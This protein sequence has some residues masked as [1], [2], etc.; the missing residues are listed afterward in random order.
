VI[1]HPDSVE[2]KGTTI[3]LPE[4]K[5]GNAANLAK[6]LN[7]NTTVPS[8]QSVL[9]SLFVLNYNDTFKA[10]K[11]AIPA[12]NSL[13]A[14]A[15]QNTMFTFAQSISSHLSERR[16]FQLLRGKGYSLGAKKESFD[17]NEAIAC[18][19]LVKQ[20]PPKQSPA[21]KGS[22]LLFAKEKSRFDVWVDGFTEFSHQG[23]Q[24]ET[25]AFDV[26]SGAALFGFDSQIGQCGSVGAA[27]GYAHD[28]I[29][30]TNDA[31][32]H[33]IDFYTVSIYGTGWSGNVFFE[34]EAW[35]TCNQYKNERRIAFLG[36]EGNAKSS[37]MGAQITSH[38][39]LGYDFVFDW[40]VIEPFAVTDW[41]VNFQNRYQEHGADGLDMIISGSTSSMLRVEAGLSNYQI[42]KWDSAAL[43]LREKASYV[44]K[45]PFST[46][47]MTAAIVGAAGT[48]GQETFTTAQNLFCPAVELFYRDKKGHFFS[49]LY[50]GEFFSGYT[51]NLASARLGMYF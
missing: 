16:R 24:N 2:V 23:A 9:Q 42:W 1:Y 37:C 10:L 41:V 50:E 4:F 36:F 31:G 11:S 38:A 17:E 30:E 39:G 26:A 51:T 49:L 8:L 3:V 5:K 19:Q 25:P 7:N 34:G 21:P 28:A 48:F 32:K 47:K 12:R 43:I 27:V 20:Q 18:A 13:T 22:T 15:S 29:R 6:Y 14:F 40:A 46:G 33:E 35:G 45:K 44:V